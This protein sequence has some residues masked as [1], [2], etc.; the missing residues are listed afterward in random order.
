[1]QVVNA[2]QYL[3]FTDLAA[4]ATQAEVRHGH[5]VSVGVSG[6]GVVRVLD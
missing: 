4:N 1:M 3:L 6:H 2:T 5:G